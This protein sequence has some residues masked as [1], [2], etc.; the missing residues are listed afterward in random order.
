M[1]LEE[2]ALELAT[3]AIHNADQEMEAQ[4]LHRREKHASWVEEDTRANTQLEVAKKERMDAGKT[5]STLPPPPPGAPPG[6]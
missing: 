1:L 2:H 4:R 3:Q 6:Q 5:G